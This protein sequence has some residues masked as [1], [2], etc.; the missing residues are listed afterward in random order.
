MKTSVFQCIQ[1]NPNLCIQQK[2]PC[3]VSILAT[4]AYSRT[5]IHVGFRLVYQ[6]FRLL[7]LCGRNKCA[8]AK[9]H[10]SY[11]PNNHQTE[12]S[13]GEMVL[14]DLGLFQSDKPYRNLR[15]WVAKTP[16]KT[17]LLWTLKFVPLIRNNPRNIRFGGARNSK[18][19]NWKL[20]GLFASFLCFLNTNLHGF[21]IY[22]SFIAILLVINSVLLAR[23]FFHIS[24][25]SI[26]R[27]KT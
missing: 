10:S 25:P 21:S 27:E 19:V 12:H 3:S 5:S 11:S 22:G 4:W 20:S 7:H 13:R 15:S 17:M 6:F 8:F 26:S 23:Y 14:H 24:E 18:K 2:M 1:K 16:V 9:F